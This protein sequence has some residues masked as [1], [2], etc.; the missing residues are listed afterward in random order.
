MPCMLRNA[1][2]LMFMLGLVRYGER[3]CALKRAN[4]G[5]SG[6]K[7]RSLETITR[8]SLTRPPTDWRDTEGRL[9]IAHLLMDVPKDLFQGPLTN[10]VLH[11]SGDDDVVPVDELY[12]VVEMQ[13]SLTHD[14]VY[15]KAEAI[16]TWYGLC[17]H[18]I[19]PVFT[20]V[21]FVLFHRSGL[22]AGDQYSRVDVII[23]YVLLGGA[24]TLE[25]VSTL[26]VMFSRWPSAIL[27]KLAY[28]M[29]GQE[30]R[31]WGLLARSIA[32]IRRFILPKRDGSRWWWSCSMGQQNLID[33]CVGSRTSPKSKIAVWMGVEVWWNTL[34]YSHS[35]PVSRT[36]KE[37]LV[38][39]VLMSNQGRKD[40]YF[41]YSKSMEEEPDHIINSRGRAA[42]QKWRR[43]YDL[44]QFVNMNFDQSIL[45][46]HIATD[47]YLRWRRDQEQVDADH[48]S[49]LAEATEA[50]SNYML[51]LL[52]ARPY[53][54]PGS[55]SRAMYVDMCYCLTSLNCHRTKDLVNF[56][57]TPS[58]SWLEIFDRTKRGHI[59][60][61]KTLQAAY[62]LACKLC[63]R[64]DTLEMISQVWAEMLCY[65]GYKCS[66][67]S[68]AKQL[69]NGGELL[70]VA[71]LVVE[72][73]RRNILKPRSK[74]EEEQEVTRATNLLATGRLT[75]AT[76][77]DLEP[78]RNVPLP[79][80]GF[81]S[82][83][84]PL[85][86]PRSPSSEPNDEIS[87][88]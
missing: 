85:D 1:S 4:T 76:E 37:L 2:V 44:E 12:K 19:S 41:L 79:L 15:S 59:R 58:Y 39:Q 7:Y 75:A 33:L 43:L 52:A 46:W 23:T 18:V 49:S 6:N 31:V 84:A 71:A 8:S 86:E 3:V 64:P 17:I 50:I 80:P 53:M 60:R 28:G 82:L 47:I 57:T 21:A 70:T 38:K 36:V 68:H 83:E 73:Y 9:R 35:I 88:V 30:R 42:L 77:I 11:L 54:L 78:T 65:A 51:F 5:A 55:V 63:G 72:Y 10:I 61:N 69:S 16:Q 67:Y 24:V 40:E 48:V 34:V 26:R 13:L 87:P 45:A 62:K 14:V 27:G 25:M 22:S 32:Y 66:G 74:P 81:G 29:A 20:V 56:L